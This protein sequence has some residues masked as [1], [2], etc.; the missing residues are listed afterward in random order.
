MMSF[1][2]RLLG[3][4]RQEVPAV[5]RS[6]D[7]SNG[8]R[9]GQKR[10]EPEK[11]IM[12]SVLCETGS[13]IPFLK[14]RGFKPL[15]ALPCDLRKRVKLELSSGYFSYMRG[16]EKGCGTAASVFRVRRRYITNLRLTEIIQREQTI[17]AKGTYSYERYFQTRSVLYIIGPASQVR[18]TIEQELL[19][20]QQLHSTIGDLYT[21]LNFWIGDARYVK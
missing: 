18:S 21:A 7:I 4:K 3:I 8:K 16:D 9:P 13:P 1:L 12:V 15:Q 14:G 19:H 2:R 10:T 11:T 20:L 17:V 5:P 6:I